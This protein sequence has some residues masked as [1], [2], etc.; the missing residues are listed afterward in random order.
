MIL[1]TLRSNPLPIPI[2]ENYHVFSSPCW[3]NGRRYLRPFR[4]HPEPAMSYIPICQSFAPI[5]FGI[6]K[7]MILSRFATKVEIEYTLIKT[8]RVAT[9]EYG[10]VRERKS[11]LPESVVLLEWL[12]R[13]ACLCVSF[14]YPESG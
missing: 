6:V 1:A 14:F 2:P 9:V 7:D 13:K 10:K 11:M 8:S 12:G 5:D 3:L 4:G